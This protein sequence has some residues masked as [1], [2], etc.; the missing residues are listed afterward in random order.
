MTTGQLEVRFAALDWSPT[1]KRIAIS[2]FA[3]LGLASCTGGVMD[4]GPPPSPSGDHPVGMPPALQA[5]WAEPAD[6]WERLV[7]QSRLQSL[8]FRSS[9]STA[10]LI[11][12]RS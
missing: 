2:V 10:A 4:T 11:S 1:M 9:A 12:G 3:A 7:E 6:R 5:T 8:T